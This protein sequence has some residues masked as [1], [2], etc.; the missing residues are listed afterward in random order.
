M[1]SQLGN[2]RM[3]RGPLVRQARGWLLGDGLGLEGEPYRLADYPN[4][5]NV[6][7]KLH[8]NRSTRRFIRRFGLL[9][10]SEL[11]LAGETPEFG[12][13]P[14]DG[15]AD[16]L[17]WM[18]AQARAV[19]L[20]TEM[21]EALQHDDA[22][23]LAALEHHCG[24]VIEVET[25]QM[26]SR[27][28]GVASVRQFRAAVGTHTE[29]FTIPNPWLPRN[30]AEEVVTELVNRNTA[31]LR[32]QWSF[33][34]DGHLRASLVPRALIEA[35]WVLVG[36]WG[37]GKVRLCERDRCKAP[38]LVLDDRQLYCPGEDTYLREGA[39]AHIARSLC[40][41]RAAEE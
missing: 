32:L 13:P 24:P 23:I 33:G 4:L 26:P 20:A 36:E 27:R 12:D 21:I 30:Q 38:F 15:G 1:T 18:F 34:E 3:R 7:A 39:R 17:F 5:P 2:W 14:Y 29:D 41:V 16:P 19:R 31:H 8:D 40:A 10:Y 6:V 37:G 11:I 25:L 22:T 28:P 35:V 9:G